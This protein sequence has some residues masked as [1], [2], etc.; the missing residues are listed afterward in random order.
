M[1]VLKRSAGSQR[2]KSS[3][4][5]Q[6][7]L[8]NMRFRYPNPNHVSFKNAAKMDQLNHLS[9]ILPIPNIANPS[10]AADS[11][12]VIPGSVCEQ[13][14]TYFSM[15]TQGGLWDSNCFRIS[16]PVL[17]C[18]RQHIQVYAVHLHCYKWELVEIFLPPSKLD[19]LA[20]M[21]TTWFFL[22]LILCYHHLMIWLLIVS[23]VGFNCHTL[24]YLDSGTD[25]VGLAGWC[26]SYT[27][28]C[29]QR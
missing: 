1:F 24:D 20:V 11:A 8:E 21:R 2:S 16:L 3:R 23:L 12:H 27:I 9:T 25:G 10:S 22:V 28:K 18:V 7:R 29:L 14:C 6:T 19:L 15:G 5:S 4:C 13:V 26:K 17:L